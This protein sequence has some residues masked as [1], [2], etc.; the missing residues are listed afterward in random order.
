MVPY[1]DCARDDEIHFEHFFFFIINNVFVVFLAEV[2]RFEAKSDI[3]QEF[4]VFV[5]LRVEEKAEIVENVIK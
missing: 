4:A 3:I 2:A 1:A 5:L